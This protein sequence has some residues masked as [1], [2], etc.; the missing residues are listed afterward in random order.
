MKKLV[1]FFSDALYYKALCNVSKTLIWKTEKAHTTTNTQ[2]CISSGNKSVVYR[3]SSVEDVSNEKGN[4]H[5][6]K[7][8]VKQ[9]I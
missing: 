9:D 8:L 2:V 5:K 3:G 1:S 7:Q 6:Y 4:A